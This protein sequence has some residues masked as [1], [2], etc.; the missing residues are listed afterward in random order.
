MLG[1]VR[2]EEGK[3]RADQGGLT[4]PVR[5]DA[6]PFVR[7]LLEP[8]VVQQRELTADRVEQQVADPAVQFAQVE[9]QEHRSGQQQRQQQVVDVE[10]GA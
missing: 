3:Q 2:P 6:W 1:Q 7:H 4:G 8:G 5:Q 9:Q 10:R